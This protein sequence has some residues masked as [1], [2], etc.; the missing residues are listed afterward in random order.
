MLRLQ[1]L[2]NEL[3][4]AIVSH[5]PQPGLGNFALSCRRV[6]AAVT[7]L[8]HGSVFFWQ[9]ES[10]GFHIVYFANRRANDPSTG[11]RIFDLDAFARSI[12]S[13]KSSRAFVTNIDDRW[14][15]K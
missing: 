10:R 8:K 4:L 12:I 5:A 13:L 6:N 14:H 1:N 3:L 15:I 9:G 11:S 2:P 7:P